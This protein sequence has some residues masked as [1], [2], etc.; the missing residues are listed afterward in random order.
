M[1]F[2]NAISSLLFQVLSPHGVSSYTAGLLGATL[3]GSG[4]VAA[5]L[6]SPI[7]GHFHATLKAIQ[8][9]VPLIGICYLVFIWVPSQPIGAAYAVLATLGAIS[10]TLLP[11]TLEWLAEDTR[12]V[13]PEVSSS[14]CWMGGQLMGVL[15]VLIMQTLKNTNDPSLPK[16]DMT[17]YDHPNTK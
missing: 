5:I 7:I 6:L 12:P 1:G 4:L 8:L 16:G 11:L 17:R 10:F 3:I 9:A 15:F 2:F 14:I 13:S